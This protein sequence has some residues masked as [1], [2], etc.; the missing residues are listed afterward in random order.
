M[1]D[2]QQGFCPLKSTILRDQDIRIQVA[3]IDY[4][5]KFK[6]GKAFINGVEGFWSFAK[7]RLIKYQ[8][9]SKYNSSCI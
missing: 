7:E 5:Y 2:L 4:R 8:G 1:Q 6:E 3:N 9:I